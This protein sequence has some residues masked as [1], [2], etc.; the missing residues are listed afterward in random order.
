MNATVTSQDQALLEKRALLEGKDLTMRF[1]GLVAMAEVDFSLRKGEVLGIIGP[2]G[3]GKTTLFDLIS[4][5]LRADSG[6]VS[7]GGRDVTHMGP[8]G[9]ADHG[10]GRSFQDAA[11]FSSLTVEQTIAVACERWIKVRDPF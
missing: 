7:L 2:N 5:Y 11:L 10:L 9:R 1:G 8:A 4:G 3:A 6:R